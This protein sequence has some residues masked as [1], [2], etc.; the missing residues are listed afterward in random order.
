MQRDKFNN[1]KEICGNGARFSV[2][3]HRLHNPLFVLGSMQAKR[4]EIAEIEVVKFGSGGKRDR[5]K[6]VKLGRVKWR[7]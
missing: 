1:G 5:F 7:P 3:L 6:R 2:S 4:Q